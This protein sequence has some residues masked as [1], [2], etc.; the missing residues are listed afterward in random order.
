MENILNY[1]DI[2]R[3]RDELFSFVWN[4]KHGDNIIYNFEILQELYNVKKVTKNNI[5]NKPIIIITVSI[6]EAILIDFIYRL[7]GA[8]NHQPKELDK[9]TIFLIK[10]E[11]ERKKIKKT[12]K[13]L[14]EQ[15][16]ELPK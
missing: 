2:K 6:I 12:D 9:H 11:I 7:Y 16:G 15:K 5:L 10:D 1:T 4:F 8:T 3:I 14:H 13:E